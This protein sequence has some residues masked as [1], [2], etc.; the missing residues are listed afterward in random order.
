MNYPERIEGHQERPLIVQQRMIVT[1]C[2]EDNIEDDASTDESVSDRCESV[3]PDDF[4]DDQADDDDEAYVYRH[5]RSGD[6]TME[7]A[8][9]STTADS[10]KIA[11]PRNSDAV[12]SCPACFRIVCMDCQRH[13]FYKNQYRAMFVMSVM[14]RWDLRLRYDPENRCLVPFPHASNIGNGIRTDHDDGDRGPSSRF[15]DPVPSVNSDEHFVETNETVYYTVC[16]A[17]CH[18][19]VAALDMTDEVYHFSGCLASS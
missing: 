7:D 2:E 19:T 1:S 18:T 11:K 6:P 4:F 8:T 3:V 14:V 12:L 13:E 16:C 5:L 9:S 15:H 17:N 10:N